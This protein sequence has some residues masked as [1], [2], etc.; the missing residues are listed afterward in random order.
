M[1][2]NTFN[3]S[4]YRTKGWHRIKRPM[5]LRPFYALLCSPPSSNNLWFIHQ[6]SLLWL[7]QKRLVVKRG[8]SGREMFAEF[9]LSISLSYLKGSLTCKILRYGADSFTSPSKE[10]L[11][12]IFIALRNRL[13]NHRWTIGGPQVDNRWTTGRHRW[14]TGWPQVDNRLITV[15]PH[16]D[17]RWTTDRPHVDHRWTTDRPHIDHRWTTDKLLPQRKNNFHGNWQERKISV[18][19]AWKLCLYGRRVIRVYK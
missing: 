17:H 15:R 18:K 5:Q 1:F 9:C 8:E 11:I 6:S 4:G 3:N 14:T 10:V 13:L 19:T 12:R 7:H 16:L 2:S